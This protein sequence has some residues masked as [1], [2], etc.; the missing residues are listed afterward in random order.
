MD[1]RH[2]T[3]AAVRTGFVAAALV[4]G[5]VGA[6]AFA[7]D[8]QERGR[9]DLPAVAQAHANQGDQ[10]AAD[11]QDGRHGQPGQNGQ[12]GPEGRQH[13]QAD[14]N[15]QHD[16]D[17]ASTPSNA[18]KRED[19]EDREDQE[20]RG[21][22]DAASLVHRQAFSGVVT[23]TAG[24]NSFEMVLEVAGGSQTVTVVVNGETEFRGQNHADL[25]DA[26]GFFAM[27]KNL[28]DNNGTDVRATVRGELTEVNNKTQIVAIQVSLHEV[29]TAEE[30]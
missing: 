21:N 12:P 7:D 20:S 8:S 16:Q 15:T 4:A 5:M 30:V 3:L 22:G 1:V 6:T 9:P 2:T 27:L 10:N 25:D 13:A 19:Q 14:Q 26:K 11:G 29:P 23:K 18:T 17:T 28:V 24:N